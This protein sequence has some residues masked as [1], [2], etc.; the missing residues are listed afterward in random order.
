MN[1]R[2]GF[3]EA[4]K[5]VEEILMRSSRYGG[6]EGGG[7]SGG[8]FGDGEGV[9]ESRERKKWSKKMTNMQRWQETEMM[10]VRGKMQREEESR[11]QELRRASEGLYDAGG[12]ERERK[13][14]LKDLSPSSSHPLSSG[15]FSDN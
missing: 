6:R 13:Q 8:F 9:V 5:K 15:K 2:A 7:G 12:R 11:E 3:C 10:R 1:M 4:E 14:W